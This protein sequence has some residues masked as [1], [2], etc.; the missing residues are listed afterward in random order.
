MF[1]ESKGPGSNL[2]NNGYSV[3][4]GV[5]TG[6]FGLPRGLIPGRCPVTRSI[7]SIN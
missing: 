4:A 2:S 3:P 5:I 7:L 1:V 6:F